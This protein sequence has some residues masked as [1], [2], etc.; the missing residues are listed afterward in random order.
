MILRMRRRLALLLVALLYSAGP[1]FSQTGTGSTNTSDAPADKVVLSLDEFFSRAAEFE[2]Q[3]QWQQAADLY[4]RA[5]RLYPDN[6]VVR[7]RWQRAERLYSLTRRYHDPSYVNELLVLSEAQALDL[8][9]EVLRKIQ[10]HYVESIDLDKLVAQGYRNLDMALSEPIFLQKNFAKSE[11]T[12]W[13]AAR[14]QL[15]RQTR[16]KVSSV[17]GAA[18]EVVRASSLLERYGLK[19]RSAIAMEFLTAASEGLDHYSTHLS[20]NRLRDLYA[21]IDGNFVGLGVE[22]RGSA[23]GLHIVSVLPGSPA[24]EVQLHEGDEIT[25][26]DG[27][28][29]VGLTAEDAA[30]RL[31]GRADSEVSLKLKLA[32]GGVR[33]VSITRRE[34]IVHSV[35]RAKMLD[36]GRGVGYVR[37]DSFQ[38]LTMHELEQAIH[39]LQE[40][41]MTSLILDLRGNPGGLLDV[42]LQV[43][44]R[45]I[46]DGVL[47]S[48]QGRAW[49]QSWSHRA[50]PM[51]IWRFPLV[52]LVDGE[53]ASASEIFASAVQDHGRGTVVGTN[54]FG[55]GSVQS[56][57]PM[58][59]AGTG[60]RLTTARFYSPKGKALQG[61]GVKPDVEVPRDRGP[62]GE[63]IPIPRQST[64]ENDRQLRTGY[65]TLCQQLVAR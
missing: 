23:S 11:T 29:I 16:V 20:P 47:V 10:T 2:N 62:M 13:N 32:A 48:T 53:S 45:F 65:E 12:D 31:Q 42:A 9:R 38:K 54:T 39:Q 26:V 5:T 24:E 7:D 8:Y 3:Q 35:T 52:V 34:V 4:E 43:A 56:I 22:V 61:V 17:E 19:H 28:N 21:M 1:V 27:V 44:N 64:I 41:G 63:E 25:E 14:H 30:N 33:M 60:L 50:R 40:E 6:T 15:S 49:G 55:K 36:E 51:Q 37:L 46:D 18:A 59:S 58:Q 57:F